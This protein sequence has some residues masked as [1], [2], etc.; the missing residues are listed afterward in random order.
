MHRYEIV[1]FWSDADEVFVEEVSELPGCR[2]HGDSPATALANCQE[3]IDLWVD[4][5]RELG[6]PIPEPKR[7]RLA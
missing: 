3:A 1:I 5:A 6:R 7:R 4:T 2:A